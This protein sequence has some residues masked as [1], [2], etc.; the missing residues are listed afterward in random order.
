MIVIEAIL[1]LVLAPVLLIVIGVI[2]LWLGHKI[3]A[4]IFGR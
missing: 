4:C 1:F 3:L 2:W